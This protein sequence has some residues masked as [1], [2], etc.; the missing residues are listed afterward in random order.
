MTVVL[1]S[2]YMIT[3]E[4]KAGKIVYQITI[5]VLFMYKSHRQLVVIPVTEHQTLE[6]LTSSLFHLKLICSILLIA[7]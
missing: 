1:V 6:F 3:W 2:I 5:Y 7:H 4:V